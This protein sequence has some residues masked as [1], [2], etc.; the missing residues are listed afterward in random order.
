MNI[1]VTGG[2]GYI[3][4]HIAR[5]FKES[6][7]HNVIISDLNVNSFTEKFDYYKLNLARQDDLESLFASKKIDAV[8]HYAGLVNPSVAVSDPILCYESNVVGTI[9]LLKMC[10]KY[11][12]GKFIFAS[13]SAV[14]GHQ[15]TPYISEDATRAPVNPY[16]LSKMYC[17]DIIKDFSTAWNEFNYAILRYFLVT[18]VDEVPIVE[19]TKGI[20]NPIKIASQAALKIRPNITI[21]GNNFNTA[22][23]TCNRDFAHIQ[24]V[25]ILNNEILNYVSAGNNSTFNASSGDASSILQVINTM[26]HV[27]GQDFPVEVGEKRDNEYESLVADMSKVKKILGWRPQHSSLENICRSSF[28]F[29]K[30]Y[31]TVT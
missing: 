9:N 30:T 12:V 26:K 22:D 14:Y 17:E 3:G 16:G 27:S 24:D 29:E 6:L 20:N 1:L 7:H 31:C 8:F 19:T 28:E 23:G 18:G 25:P 2:A 4:S 15:S 21:F 13:S 11:N 10:K 5:Y